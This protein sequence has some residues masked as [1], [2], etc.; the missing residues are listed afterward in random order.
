MRLT[1]LKRSF[2]LI[3]A[4]IGSVPALLVVALVGAVSLFWLSPHY[5][6]SCLALWV[7][8]FCFYID[9]RHLNYTLITPLMGLA[10]FMIL[11][12]AV[13][14]ALLTQGGDGATSN[15]LLLSQFSGVMSGLCLIWGYWLVMRRV[16]AF[17]LP[18][19]GP[20]R[21]RLF[22]R[23]LNV[24]G[25]LLLGHEFMRVLIGA[26]SGA[27]D[28][29]EAGDFITATPFGIWT[30]FGFMG[31]IQALGFILVPL[32][33]QRA[34][35]VGRAVLGSVIGM[36]IIIHFAAAARGSVVFPIFLMIIGTFLFARRPKRLELVFIVG[37]LAIAPLLVLMG[38]FR[39][40]AEFRQS[41][42]SNIG[43]R[44]STLQFAAEA[45][46]KATDSPGV[47]AGRAFIGT[48][49]YMVYDMTP[50]VI[51]HATFDG[52][53]S[54][55][56]VMV[57]YILYRDRPILQDG[58]F[59]AQQYL[60]YELIRTSI[61]I[62]L[63]ADLYRRFGWPAVPLGLFIYGLFYGAVFRWIY[64]LYYQRNALLGFLLLGV[65]MNYFIGWNFH[66]VPNVVHGW[67][68]NTFFKHFLVMAVGYEIL[69]WAMKLPRR[70]G[71]TAMARADQAAAAAAEQQRAERARLDRVVVP[72]A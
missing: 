42:L 64:W 22:D 60:G 33:W 20:I 30:L 21:E 45:A 59:I 7:G 63:P 9:R 49:D 67:V 15:G 5:S 29:G 39:S 4:V 11:G 58:K 68:Y 66:S 27:M 32:C 43:Q 6:L 65:M 31:Q 51:P 38:N 71:A 56:W 46:E 17:V 36:I 19:P 25:W 34:N 26:F 52:L 8:L 61:G 10:Q 57:P 47:Q 70:R 2:P 44:L 54:I 50:G 1:R 12:H 35:L 24:V 48:L 18:A 37:L 40:T 16:P 13:G 53:D 55:L 3:S 62:T 69:Q 28:R 72:L 14:P 41:S 23:P